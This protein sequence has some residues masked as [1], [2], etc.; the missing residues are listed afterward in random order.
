MVR[1][2]VG[3]CKEKQELSPAAIGVSL[4]SLVTVQKNCL[5]YTHN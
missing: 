4:G 1:L 3:T 2:Y 5:A